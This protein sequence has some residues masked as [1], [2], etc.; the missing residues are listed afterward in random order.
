MPRTS[1]ARLGEYRLSVP[2]PAAQRAVADFL[3]RETARIDALTAAKCSAIELSHERWRAQLASSMYPQAMANAV[4]EGR[5]LGSTEE[6]WTVQK[7]L[8]LTDR[9]VPIAYG[10]LKPGEHVDGGV[11]YLGA[12]DVRPGRMDLAELPRTSTAIAKD[13]PRTRLTPGDL[14][15]AIRGSF[16][17]V[18]EVPD[19]LSGANL[20]RDVAR[21]SPGQAVNSRWLMYA[22]KTELAQEQFRRSEVGATITGVNIEDLRNVR[23]IV[24]NLDQQVRTVRTLDKARDENEELIAAQKRHI[25]LLRERRQ[26]LISSAVTG[27]LELLEEK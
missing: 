22:L 27:R 12:G 3:D 20:S 9:R 23:L 7:L 13:Y 25:D 26:A 14:V 4:L 5:A 8:W 16:G 19:E 11:P 24:P 6:G 15:Y 18:E 17:A 10:I 21:I 1:W 2:S